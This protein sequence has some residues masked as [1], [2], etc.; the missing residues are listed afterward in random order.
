[1]TWHEERIRTHAVDASWAQDGEVVVLKRE[2]KRALAKL[3]S[4]HLAYLEAEEAAFRQVALLPVATDG[5][6]NILDHQLQI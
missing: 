1:M 5:T 3:V 6:L 4:F 2:A